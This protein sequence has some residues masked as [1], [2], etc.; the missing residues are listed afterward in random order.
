MESRKLKLNPDKQTLLLLALNNNEIE[1][2]T[3][4]QLNCLAVIHS[5]QILFAILV[6]SLIVISTFA[7]IFLKF[8]NPVSIIIICDLR[9]IRRHISISTAK[10]ISGALISSRLDYCN[11]LLNNIAKRELAKLQRVENC[12]AHVVL[13]A[14]YCT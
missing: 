5:H 13:R 8:V 4:F 12:L 1:S 14:T 11:S 9:R 10:T 2:S 3:I 7:S 6:L